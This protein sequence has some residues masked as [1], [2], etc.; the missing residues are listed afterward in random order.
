MLGVM[1]V[2]GRVLVL[3]R[4]A[5][6]DVSAFQAQAEMN[7]GV[8]HLQTFLAAFATGGYVANLTEVSAGLL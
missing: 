8:A 6:T 3:G 1:E 7:P 4:I 5:A 2:L